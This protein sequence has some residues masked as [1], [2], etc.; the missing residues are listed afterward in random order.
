MWRQLKARF[1]AA[2]A[3][4]QRI[5]KLRGIREISHAKLIKPFKRA[6][7]PLALDDHIDLKFLSVH[8]ISL[9]PRASTAGRSPAA[10]SHSA[11]LA[12]T[13]ARYRIPRSPGMG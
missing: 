9:A 7:S 8:G 6:G 10:R 11:C 12:A 4:G 3:N 5:V 13:P 2:V 1:N